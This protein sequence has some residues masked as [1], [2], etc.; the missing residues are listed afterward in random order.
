MK[1]SIKVFLAFLFISFQTTFAS[2]ILQEFLDKFSKLEYIEYKLIIEDN[3][4]SEKPY[5]SESKGIIK[6]V[7]RDSLVG[8]YF[9]FKSEDGQY[10]FNGS[11]LYQY[12][13][14]SYGDSIVNLIHVANNPGKFKAD[15]IMMDGQMLLTS[16]IQQSSIFYCYSIVDFVK[17]LKTFK[18]KNTVNK[19]TVI[20]GV[21]AILCRY[22]SQDTII[23]GTRNYYIYTFVFDKLSK[24]P[25]YY[26]HEYLLPSLGV[27]AD[28]PN[29]LKISYY[30]YNF[31]KKDDKKY[32][33]KAAIDKKYKIVE[34][35]PFIER[36]ELLKVGEKAPSWELTSL[37]GKKYLMKESNDK[38]KFI[39]FTKI[40]CAPCMLSVPK[41]NELYKEFPGIDILAIYPLDD[42]KTLD[43]YKKSK[44]IEY[45]I[46]P[47]DTSVSDLYNIVGYPAFYLVD[48]NGII[49]F[50]QPGYGEGSKEKFKE[51]IE[52]LLK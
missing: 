11:E 46:L 48:K 43:S 52:K 37:D 50:V 15:T 13:V 32:F 40:N 51:A 26:T 21:D 10:I 36:K 16:P 35:A 18:Y 44:K 33:S 39:T 34:N 49:Q 8:F 17:D 12:S 5:R 22:I 3:L 9:N 2:D 25:M 45:P 1:T 28:L 41:L 47:T 38:I 24:F 23:D 30:D 7:P 20:K 27:G 29:L 14:C 31:D 19:D 4:L 42:K 6:I